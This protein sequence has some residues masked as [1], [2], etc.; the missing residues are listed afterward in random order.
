VS[1]LVGMPIECF[2]ALLNMTY[3]RASTSDTGTL[4][5]TGSNII[6]QEARYSEN[7]TITLEKASHLKLSCNYIN[8]RP[9][10]DDSNGYSLYA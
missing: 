3:I 8:S 2:S 6:F 7:S 5:V 4:P 9:G 10:N 1:A